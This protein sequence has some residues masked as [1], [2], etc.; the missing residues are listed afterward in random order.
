MNNAICLLFQ[1]ILLPTA[2][3]IVCVAS[4][5]HGSIS[6]RNIHACSVVLPTQTEAMDSK[7]NDA[8]PE[9]TQASTSS[10]QQVKSV[11]TSPSSKVFQSLQQAVQGGLAHDATHWLNVVAEGSQRNFPGEEKP[12]SA[13]NDAACRQHHICTVIA[14]CCS[15]WHRVPVEKS[16]ASVSLIQSGRGP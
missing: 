1:I 7:A 8:L 13:V 12:H 5:V 2:A 16:S 9:Q 3:C 10:M 11:N 14:A 4:W 6:H 15:R